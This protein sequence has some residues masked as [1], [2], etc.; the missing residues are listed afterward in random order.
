MVD[1]V[2]GQKHENPDSEIDG[3]KPEN[4]DSELDGQKPEN[5]DSEFDGQKP[6]S[7]DCSQNLEH[8]EVSAKKSET[9]AANKPDSVAAP[10]AGRVIKLNVFSEL[11][12][13]ESGE[14]NADGQN[15][16]RGETVGQ[17]PHRADADGQNTQKIPVATD[18]PEESAANDP[19]PNQ[20]K[21]CILS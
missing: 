1:L 9:S 13:N 10:S 5:P 6:E 17:N 20:G 18:M 3:Q 8:A 2:D 14:G 16:H 19:R 11:E 15:P 7:L 21:E 12:E 4:P